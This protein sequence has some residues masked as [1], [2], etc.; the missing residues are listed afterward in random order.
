MRTCMPPSR[1]W[2]LRFSLATHRMKEAAVRH[3]LPA[4]RVPAVS[5]SRIS[6]ALVG[7]GLVVL[8]SVAA[9]TTTLTTTRVASGLFRPVFVTSPPGD[10]RLFIVEQRGADNRGRVKILKDGVVLAKAFLTTAALPTGNEQGLYSI[11]FPP[12]YAT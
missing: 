5:P 8:A 2:Q 9:A 11:A 6:V 10:D 3:R 12:D 4:S 1:P 7:L